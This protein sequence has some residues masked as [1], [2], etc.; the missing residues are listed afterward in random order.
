MPAATFTREA[1][2]LLEPGLQGLP[3]AKSRGLGPAHH[4]RP[5]GR[6]L[7]LLILSAS[8]RS[9]VPGANIVNVQ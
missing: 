8:A 5:G 7:V 6:D 2:S 1:H 9:P 4:H 3:R